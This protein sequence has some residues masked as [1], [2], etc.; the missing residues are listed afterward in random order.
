MSNRYCTKCGEAEEQV[1][2]ENGLPY[3]QSAKNGCV[4]RS[5]S[6]VAP[7]VEDHI[8]STEAED[9]AK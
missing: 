1:S 3:L 9:A 8:W 6:G 5:L 2:R 7:V 4:Q